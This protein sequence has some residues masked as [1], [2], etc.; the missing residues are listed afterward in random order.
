VDLLDNSIQPYAWGSS[1]AIAELL[2][3]PT[4]SP[5]PEAELWMGAHPGAP[6]SVDRDGRSVTLDTVISDDPVRELGAACL[7]AFGPRLP[8]LFKVI[9]AEAA[10]SIQVHPT[11]T[12]ARAG[13]AAERRDGAVDESRLNYRDDW[14]KPE[15]L[16]ALT[17]FEALAGLREAAEAADVLDGLGVEA[18]A[19]P[20]SELRAEPTAASVARV[21]GELLELSPGEAAPLVRQV[22]AAAER[23]AKAGGEHTATYEAVGRLDADHPDDVGV[24][25]SLLLRHVVLAPGEAM[26]MPAGGLHAYVRGVGVELMANSDNVLRAGLTG[27][28]IDVAELLSVLDPE[29]EVPIVTPRQVAPGVEVFEP[30]VPEIRLTRVA[31]FGKDLAVPGDGPRVLLCVEGSAVVRASD[32]DGETLLLDQGASCYVSAAD[33]DVIVTGTGTI[34]QASA[35]LPAA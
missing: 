21:L 3:R 12:Q 20:V 1:I 19:A 6:S 23:L 33:G 11:R 4:P 27:K 14:P 30:P 10:L 16:C 2:G 32:S 26:F 5:G 7:D 31:A 28:R 22:V 29:V 25:G 17:D 15:M 34:F 24:V 18:L 35:G 13:Y 9:A 8:F